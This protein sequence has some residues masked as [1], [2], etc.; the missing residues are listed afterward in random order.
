M[1]FAWKL[2]KKCLVTATAASEV[3][4]LNGTQSTKKM[5]CGFLESL[6]KVANDRNVVEALIIIR[7]INTLSACVSH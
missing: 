7:L 1:K 2:V 3:I 6:G 5:S 4:V